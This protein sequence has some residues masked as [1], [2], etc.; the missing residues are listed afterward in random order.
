MISTMVRWKPIVVIGFFAIFF[1]AIIFF[2]KLTPS[3]SDPYASVDALAVAE[4]T[5]GFPIRLTIPKINVDAA[6]E[7]VGV[8]PQG[9]MGVPKGPAT[10]AWFDLGPRPGEKGSAVIDGHFGWKNKISAVFDNLSK[11][12]KG[13]KIYVKDAK[14]AVT[15]FV[16]RAVLIYGEN[17]DASRIFESSDG[18][19]HLNLI[20]CEGIWD[21][22]RKSYSGRLIVFADKEIK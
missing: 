5:S 21:N 11:L 13:D 17:A 19:M 7:P 10:A 1:S 4:A 16:V 3:G 8:T 22:V 2:M 9:A 18:G 14:G 15:A 20:T 12:R 6:I